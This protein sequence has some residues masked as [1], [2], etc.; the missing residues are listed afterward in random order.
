MYFRKILH[1]RSQML[2]GFS[3]CL[4]TDILTNSTT[5][6]SR[7]FY[8]ET[9]WKQF[10]VVLTWNTR[11]IF[12][13]WPFKAA[14]Q[15]KTST[16]PAGTDFTLQLHVEIKFRPGKARQFFTWY[17]LRFECIF[18]VFFYISISVYEIEDPQISINLR[19]FCL[20]CLVFDCVYSFS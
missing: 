4:W 15:D 6:T 19:N 12:V 2:A 1:A 11:D 17:F 20:S 9:S 18:F 16:H 14:C 13:G 3:K 10:H 7:V 5:N 8:V